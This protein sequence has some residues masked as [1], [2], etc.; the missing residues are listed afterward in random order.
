M[1]I[2]MITVV[3][4]LVTFIFGFLAKK[5]KFID[6]NKIP[7]QNLAIGLVVAA[8]EFIITKDFKV[9]L[10]LSGLLAGG[11]YDLFH[12]LKKILTAWLEIEEEKG[13]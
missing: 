7:F 3:T 8:I 5:S 4:M 11:I 2:N 1:E 12:N 9:A 10:S 6:N 13:E